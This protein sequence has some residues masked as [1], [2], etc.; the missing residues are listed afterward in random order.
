[1]DS[2]MQVTPELLGECVEKIDNGND[3]LVIPEEAFGTT[4]WAK[5][6]WMEKKCYEGVEEIEA[7]RVMTRAA[8]DKVGGHN[9]DMV[10]SEDKDLDLRIRHAGYTV[11]RTKS[12]LYHN[13]GALKLTRSIK[14]KL[15]YS[16]TANLFET[17]HPDTFRYRA[18]PFN[19]Y[20]LFLKNG[21]Y[22]FTHPFI[23]LGLF[24][25]ITVEFGIGGVRFLYLK[26]KKRKLVTA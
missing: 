7:L 19:R 9:E 20:A 8:Y 13:E 26:L 17:T 16:N 18:N 22:L 12:F 6:K 3:A 23:Y 4:F 2:D 11:G 24:Y 1:M 5:C 21:K 15:F 25:M 14:K 10:F